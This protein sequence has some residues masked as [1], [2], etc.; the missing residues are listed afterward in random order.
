MGTKLQ[1]ALLP[2]AQT[3][4][5]SL[6]PLSPQGPPWRLLL[7]PSLSL[8]LLLSITESLDLTMEM[9]RLSFTRLCF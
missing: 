9:N 1:L 7:P 5:P 4:Q 3:Y 2:R 6:T 8:S